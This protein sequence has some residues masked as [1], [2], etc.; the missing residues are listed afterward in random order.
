MAEFIVGNSLRKLAREHSLLRRALWRLDFML[1]WLIVKL[2]RTLPVDAASRYGERVGTWVGARLKRKT[3]IFKEN[4][5]VV[6]PGMPEEELEQLVRRAWGCAGRVLAEYPHLDTILKEPGRLELDIREHIESYDRPDR[7]CV[8]VSAHLCNWEVICSA[9][10]KMGMPNASLYS[11]PTNPLLDQLLRDHR[12]ALNSELLPRDNS[13]R[14]LMRALKQGRT[15]GMVM[16]RRVD[17]GAPVTFFGRDK[18]STLVPARLALKFNCELVPAQVVR[19]K[20]ARYRVI[21]H[22]PIRPAA[23]C[24]NEEERALDMTRQLHAQ[25]EDW[26][27]ARPE[28]WFCSKRMWSRVKIEPTEENGREA[29][30]DSYAA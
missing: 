18:P 2:A 1:I 26:I 9:M 21:F 24:V 19:L 16:D 11:P 6:F 27:R 4:M 30:I 8:M 23:D 22:P 13:A 28:D 5:Q 17:D 14:L 3:S 29:D 20:D 7:P 12:R 25:F 10:A 15:V